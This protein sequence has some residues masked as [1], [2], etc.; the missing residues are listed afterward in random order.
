M[1]CLNSL[2][3]GGVAATVP[4]SSLLGGV[5][6][7]LLL[8]LLVGGSGDDLHH[9]LLER[10]PLQLETVLVPDEVGRAQVE[11]VALHALLEDRHDVAVVGLRSELQLAAV[12]HEGLELAGLVQ[13]ELVQR[14][15]LLLSLNVVVFLVLRAAGQTLPWQGAAQEIEKHVADRLQVVTAGLLDANVRA[16]GGVTSRACQI[17]ALTVWDVLS[18]RVLVALGQAEVNDVNIVLGALTAAHQEV[19]RLD[20]AMDDALLVHFPN[21]VDLSATRISR[22]LNFGS[23]QRHCARLAQL[24]PFL[25]NSNQELK[26]SSV[27][28]IVKRE[29]DLPFG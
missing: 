6:V 10:L 23:F 3:Y 4:P 5:L 24:L 15:L 11:I 14:H 18:L 13:T 19:V 16:D 17:L 28:L 12:L 22:D 20:V 7:P 8:G 1:D 9:L 29:G 26:R 25:I 2:S 21:T 27:L